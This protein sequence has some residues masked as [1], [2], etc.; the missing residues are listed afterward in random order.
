MCVKWDVTAE[1]GDDF[2]CRLLWTGTSH[3]S[4]RNQS[5]TWQQELSLCVSPSVSLSLSFFPSLFR[6]HSLFYS[7]ILISFLSLSLKIPSF[8]SL[9]C[10]ISLL[11]PYSS[12]Y[13]L[14]VSSNSLASIPSFLLLCPS[15]YGQCTCSSC[16]PSAPCIPAVIGKPSPSST[17]RLE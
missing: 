9:P 2:Q 15:L 3:W 10:L 14:C 11:C 12:S 1:L 8:S 17:S 5:K 16:S 7:S 4:I 6:P 13:V